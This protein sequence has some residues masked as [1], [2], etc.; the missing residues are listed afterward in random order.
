M[1]ESEEDFI[2]YSDDEDVYEITENDRRVERQ[3][4]E[5]DMEEDDSFLRKVSNH[6]CIYL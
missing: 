2:D 1:T 3:D 5:M 6:I 4:I